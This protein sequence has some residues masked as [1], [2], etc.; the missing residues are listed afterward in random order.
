M[1]RYYY[2]QFVFRDKKLGEHVSIPDFVWD[3]DEIFYTVNENKLMIWN[4]LR[5]GNLFPKSLLIKE[6]AWC[7]TLAKIHTNKSV[8]HLWFFLNI[9]NFTERNVVFM[10]TI[11]KY[12]FLKMLIVSE[13]SFCS[14]ES[15]AT[16]CSLRDFNYYIFE[17]KIL[18]LAFIKTVYSL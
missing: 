18:L 12:L 3:R 2:K 1:K 5:G 17:H 6:L 15:I 11:W 14:N 16:L 13:I 4:S 7:S 10:I 8:A 9:V